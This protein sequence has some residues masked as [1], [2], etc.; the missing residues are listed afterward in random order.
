MSTLLDGAGMLTSILFRAGANI[1]ITWTVI[2][3]LI[4]ICIYV[5]RHHPLLSDVVIAIVLAVPLIILSWLLSFAVFAL[6]MRLTVG[7]DN[8]IL[9][10][11][12]CITTLV[13]L[14]T[15][16]VFVVKSVR[17]HK[18]NIACELKQGGL[19]AEAAKPV[20]PSCGKRL[21]GND[22][23]YCPYC[24][25]ML[26]HPLKRTVSYNVVSDTVTTTVQDTITGEI[27]SVTKESSP[28][29]KNI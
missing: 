11:L 6:L 5:C 21:D 22:Y 29:K 7:I 24:N 28:L 2:L 1:V 14:L 10:A 18:M 9:A 3:I 12:T 27:K 8:D 17:S 20:C 23:N 15:Y 13:V 4:T 16:I 25:T 26:K 19:A